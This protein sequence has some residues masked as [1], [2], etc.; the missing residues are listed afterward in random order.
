M[1][2]ATLLH[3]GR[4][5]VVGGQTAGQFGVAHSAEIFDPATGSWTV[6]RTP[7]TPRFSHTATLLPDGRVLVAGGAALES[8]RADPFESA[9]TYDPAA[10]SWAPALPMRQ[11]RTAHTATLLPDGRVLM[12]GGMGGNGV[13]SRAAELFDPHAGTWASTGSMMVARLSH[14]ATVLA[15]NTVLVA[16]GNAGGVAGLASASRLPTTDHARPWPRPSSSSSRCH[17]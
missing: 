3:D 4:V 1:H 6:V 14:T 11:A 10:D 12:V 2:S 13:A 8:R 16:G 7:I 15:D 9:E 5:L 17:R